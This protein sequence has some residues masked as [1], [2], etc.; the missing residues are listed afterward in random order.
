MLCLSV[1]ENSSG[2]R[3]LVLMPAMTFI[4]PVRPITGTAALIIIPI[5]QYYLDLR[6]SR[7]QKCF[8]RNANIIIPISKMERWHMI[9]SE[10]QQIPLQI[11]H[12]KL[13]DHSLQW[14][15]FLLLNSAENCLKGRKKEYRVSLCFNSVCL[16][17]N[18]IIKF[19]ADATKS[20][21]TRQK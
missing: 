21:E 13:G 5:S 8:I 17:H 9:C 7:Y 19:K 2:N 12:S 6:F 1:L 18:C 20:D 10:L 11:F 3:L 14:F 16:G 15:Y 4:I